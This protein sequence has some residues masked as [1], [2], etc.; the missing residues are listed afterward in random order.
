MKIGGY[1]I[2]NYHKYTGWSKDAYQ[3]SNRLNF[4]EVIYS[5]EVQN[6]FN[7]GKYELK[8]MNIENNYG[9]GVVLYDNFYFDMQHFIHFN[10]YY[11][12]H[13]SLYPTQLGF[14]TFGQFNKHL[15]IK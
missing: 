8:A 9:L 12:H 13:I 11:A 15:I 2:G 7:R 1:Q 10:Q 6:K 3:T 4:T 14:S 5:S